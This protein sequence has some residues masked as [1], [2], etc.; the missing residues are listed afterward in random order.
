VLLAGMFLALCLRGWLVYS[1]ASW[2]ATYAWSPTRMD[3]LLAGS[4]VAVWSTGNSAGKDVTLLSWVGLGV[5]FCALALV[6]WT[7]HGHDIFKFPG[8]TIIVLIRVFGF[9]VLALA[10]G[11]AL[12]LA[13]HKNF[14]SR[15]LGLGFF[16][17][18]A[19]YSY[20]IYLVHFLLHPVFEQAFGPVVLETYLG[21][22]ALSVG[23]Y[24]LLASLGSFLLAAVSY[25]LVE[26][27]IIRWAHQR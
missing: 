7:H 9:S 27:P 4:L 19:T 2:E 6:G 14:L 3:C 15:G 11:A 18:I 8:S 5:G 16:E 20:G 13:L 1:G 21:S 24:F 10:F 26:Q 12:F 17:P 25:R 23:L 22:H